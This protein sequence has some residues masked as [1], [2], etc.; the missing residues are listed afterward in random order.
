MMGKL[1]RWLIDWRSH[2]KTLAM[3]LLVALAVNAWQSRHVPA[4]PDPAQ[5]VPLLTSPNLNNGASL[6]AWLARHRGEV[7][8]VHFWATWCP[9]CKAS[10]DNITRLM[11]EWPIVTVA[12]QSGDE[13][14]VQRHLKK[15]RLPWPTALDPQGALAK[16]WG[17]SAVP[18]TVILNREGRIVTASMGYTSTPGLWIRLWWVRLFSR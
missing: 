15:A 6:Q 1:W 14:S 3:V 16:A 9:V 11:G 4:G 13:L 17:V 18:A 2:L 5:D 8:A 10:E 7:V 12:M